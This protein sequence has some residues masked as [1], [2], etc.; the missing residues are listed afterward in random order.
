MHK[1]KT[2]NKY[3][4]RFFVL[5]LQ[6]T[7]I[8]TFLTL[9]FFFYVTDIEKIEFQKQ[10]EIIV[11]SISNDVDLKDIIPKSVT[12]NQ[13]SLI[14]IDGVLDVIVNKVEIN[15]KNENSKIKI[16]NNNVFHTALTYVSIVIG[17]TLITLAIIFL[18]GH[19]IPITHFIKEALFA[20][21]AVA[22]V[23]YLFLNL[24]AKHY[25]S[26]EPNDVRKTLGKSIQTYIDNRNSDPLPKISINKL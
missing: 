15:A 6:I 26:A 11:D 17:F 14:M 3:V 16:N 24:I 23:E 9:F 7:L 8:F 18:L 21:L 20:V 25:I 10:L 4:H 5:L 19:C 22:I 2:K 13:N 12:T 1:C